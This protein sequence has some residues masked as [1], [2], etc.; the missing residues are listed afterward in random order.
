MFGK[1]SL[2]GLVD[3]KYEMVCC[4]PHQ[5]LKDRSSRLRNFF[6]GNEIMFA[7]IFCQEKVLSQSATLLKKDTLTK[8]F[9]QEFRKI[10]KNTIYYRTSHVAA[11]TLPNCPLVLFIISASRSFSGKIYFQIN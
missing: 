2:H 7:K 10:F 5:L 4:K 3:N 11:S 6:T 9:S 8:A 1:I